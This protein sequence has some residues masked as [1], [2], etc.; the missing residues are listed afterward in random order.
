ME[1]GVRFRDDGIS[2][3]RGAVSKVSDFTVEWGR[4]FRA[5]SRFGE[6]TRLSEEERAHEGLSRQLQMV[7]HRLQRS[8]PNRIGVQKPINLDTRRRPGWKWNV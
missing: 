2:F 6:D 5:S 7:R 4:V 1:G 8:I 3:E